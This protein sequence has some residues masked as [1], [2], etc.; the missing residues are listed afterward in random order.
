[1]LSMILIAIMILLGLGVL[2]LLVAFI[3]PLLAVVV[4]VLY[5][6]VALYSITHPKSLTTNKII[7]ELVSVPT[8]LGCI[9]TLGVGMLFVMIPITLTGIYTFV[10]MNPIN[11]FYRNALRRVYRRREQQAMVEIDTK[12]TLDTL[13]SG[14][15][16]RLHGILQSSAKGTPIIV[17]SRVYLGEEFG[18]VESS[19]H[20]RPITSLI[21]LQLKDASFNWSL[22]RELKTSLEFIVPDP[23]TIPDDVPIGTYH[24]YGIYGGDDVIIEGQ[25]LLQYR[26]TIHIQVPNRRIGYQIIELASEF[27]WGLREPTETELQEAIVK[28][29]ARLYQQH[30]RNPERE[31]STI[32][33]MMAL[34]AGQ[35]LVIEGQVDSANVSIFEDYITYQARYNFYPQLQFFSADYPTLDDLIIAFPDGLYTFNL[36]LPPPQHPKFKKPYRRGRF[37]KRSKFQFPELENPQSHPSFNASQ[38]AYQVMKIGSQVTIHAQKLLASDCADTDV[39]SCFT[40]EKIIVHSNYGWQFHPLTE[41]QERS[42]KKSATLRQNGIRFRRGK[43]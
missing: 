32:A 17:A 26:N 9:L 21:K 10:I 41:S 8:S 31:V 27:D 42:V 34:G 13:A 37:G 24:E 22:K 36:I 16:F 33:E 30:L 15:R 43:G 5:V 38:G 3:H 39:M 29:E 14:Y 20:L 28:R 25:V 1:M 40:V 18:W 2:L 23:P 19:A 6:L 4:L 35:R 11:M 12:T 7:A